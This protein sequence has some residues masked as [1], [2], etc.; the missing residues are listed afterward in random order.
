MCKKHRIEDY[1]IENGLVILSD[2]WMESQ[3]LY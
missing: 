2:M 1:T 3:Q